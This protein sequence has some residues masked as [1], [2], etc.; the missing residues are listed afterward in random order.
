MTFEK[1][2]ENAYSETMTEIFTKAKWS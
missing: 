1:F 2:I